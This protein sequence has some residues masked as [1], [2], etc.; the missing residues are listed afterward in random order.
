[1]DIPENLLPVGD[2]VV[3]RTDP[4]PTMS[5]SLHLP[6]NSREKMRTATVIAGPQPHWKGRSWVVPDPDVKPGARV[7]LTK[8]SVKSE[9]YS[10]DGMLMVVRYED[11]GAVEE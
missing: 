3:V 11:I 7:L 6:Q 2:K 5:G 1:M 10:D 4:R 8:F 9:D